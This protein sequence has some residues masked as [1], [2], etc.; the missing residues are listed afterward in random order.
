MIVEAGVNR[1]GW[2]RDEYPVSSIQDQL[3]RHAGF[4]GLR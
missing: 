1:A 4:A 3:Y 2:I